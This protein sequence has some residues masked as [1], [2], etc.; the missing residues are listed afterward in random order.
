VIFSKIQRLDWGQ[1][2][3]ANFFISPS[4]PPNLHHQPDHGQLQQQGQWLRAESLFQAR[5]ILEK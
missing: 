4:S 3:F 5:S 1:S 2:F